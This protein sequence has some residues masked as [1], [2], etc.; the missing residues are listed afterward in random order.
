MVLQNPKSF[1]TKA[2]GK[3]ESLSRDSH[4]DG[5]RKN[6]LYKNVSSE[7]KRKHT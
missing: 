4:T 2:K 5:R 1:P 3:A 6:T 7:I